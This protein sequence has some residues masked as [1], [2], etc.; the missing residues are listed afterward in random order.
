MNVIEQ[1]VK[2]YLRDTK[3]KIYYRVEEVSPSITHTYNNPL[4]KGRM[5]DYLKDKLDSSE[6]LEKEET[7]LEE[8]L[9][10]LCDEFQRVALFPNNIQRVGRRGAFKDYLLG[11]PS[12][13]NIPVY[14]FEMYTMFS[15]ILEDEDLAEELIDSNRRNAEGEKIFIEIP[16]NEMSEFFYEEIERAVNNLLVVHN[17]PTL[18]DLDI[19]K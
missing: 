9:Q 8:D 6:Y 2:E 13:V 12:N 16:T 3:N 11:L 14:Y 19:L 4:F 17:M 10:Y 5:M 7:T 15:K 1:S 18:N